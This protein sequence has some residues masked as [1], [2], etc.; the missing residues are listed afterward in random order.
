MKSL[1]LIYGLFLILLF[2]Q[3]AKQS[4]PL[5]G[6]RDE[7][8]PVLL[9]TSPGDQ[10]LNVKPSEIILTFDEYIKLDNPNK[11][12][13]ITPRLNKDEIITTALKNEVIIELN[14]EL[15]ENTTYVFNFQ[16][17]V[18]DLSEGNP[19]ENLK[20]VFST[21][22]FI[23]SLKVK[24]QVNNYWPSQQYDAR[25]VLI[26]LYLENDT[27]DLFTTAPYYLTRAD[28][29]GNF[30]IENIKEGRYKAYAWLDANNSTKA[31][32][33]SEPY[34]F[35]I[36]TLEI[37]ENL[38]GIQFNLSQSDLTDF[39]LTR[40][41]FT[42]GSYDFILNKNQIEE[43]IQV[44]GLGKDIFYSTEDKRIRLF[45]NQSIS[46]SLLVNLQLIDSVSNQI[47]TAIWAKFPEAERRPDKLTL[48]AN[49]GKNFTDTLFASIKFNKPVQNILTDSLFIPVDSANIIQI[50]E[51]MF[52]FK[53]SLKRTELLFEIPI[54][55]TLGI[56]IFT[57][58]ALD[59]TFQDIQGEFNEDPIRANYRKIKKETLA[60][61]L[62]GRIE[63]AEPP[64]IIQL[65]D[66][67]NEIYK[68]QF[69]KNT[70]QFE[71]EAIEAGTYKIRVINDQNGNERWDPGN[72]FKGRLAEPVFYFLDDT[73]AI[74]SII[75]K[76]GWTNEGIVIQAN[77][78]TGF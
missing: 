60:D 74:G 1:Q 42:N 18:Q 31:E 70:N 2:A 29:L 62:S 72:F 66:S 36:D 27:T 78:S 5:G 22:D 68:E 57:F 51:S 75:L 71:F 23:D 33:K 64:F 50:K 43:E 63:G 44:E 24:G 16:N 7:D 58:T 12:I 38:E 73:G 46:D 6:P 45:S 49:S 61:L 54:P 40:S 4:S 69:L 25:N 10:S 15:E 28:S 39:R 21:G 26:G 55:D 41:S 30:Q 67:K 48:T 8:P 19:A 14:Q 17:S 76:S 9:E 47:D 11:N 52:S 3:C 56:E 13:V 20:L 59:S 77:K 65:V 53:D 32:F 37:N 35:L 34:D